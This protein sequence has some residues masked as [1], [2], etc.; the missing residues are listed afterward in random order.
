MTD[1]KYLIEDYIEKEVKTKAEKEKVSKLLLIDLKPYM[2][3]KLCYEISVE[4]L[5][6]RDEFR[7][8]VSDAFSELLN[9][10]RKSKE[11]TR[12]RL[13]SFTNYL[14]ETWRIDL[15]LGEVFERETINPYER[16]VDL[17]KTLNE[18]MTKKQL[19]EHYSISRKTLKKDID[20][21]IMGTRIFGQKVIIRDIERERG[22]ITCQSSIHPVFLPLNLTEVYYLT[23]FL[24]QLSNSKDTFMSSIFRD[25][26]NRIYC[27]L[28]EY[29]RHKID[30]KGLQAG[31]EFPEV[32][33]FQLYSGSRD[34]E[35]M[36]RKS[37]ESTLT[38]LWK[39]G[40]PCTIHLN[41]ENM[42]ILTD[43]YI[44]YAFD[45]GEIFIK[46]NLEG[47]R[48]EKIDID[49]ILDIKFTYR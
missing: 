4:S 23:V 9:G 5:K 1:F 2:E 13:L 30:K 28:S 26:A 47:K 3:K 7:M 14:K 33:D 34:E 20:K 24:K 19:E 15:E 38:Y 29:A 17:L 21:L 40:A 41:N 22:K 46:N 44:D 39:A 49:K 32:E 37:K 8:G 25:L 31:I 11:L 27:Q 10:T 18:G 35:K 43:V 6:V 48:E 12:D 16:L 45:T 36:A 42:D